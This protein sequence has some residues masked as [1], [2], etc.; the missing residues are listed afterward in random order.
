MK[1]EIPTPDRC[2]QVR[3]D[4]FCEDHLQRTDKKTENRPEENDIAQVCPD[5]NK[6][7]LFHLLD[8]EAVDFFHHQGVHIHAL[9]D[10]RNLCIYQPEDESVKKRIK[11]FFMILFQPDDSGDASLSIIRKGGD[12]PTEKKKG[13]I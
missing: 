3:S 2:I 12:E 5:H 4:K 11:T 6:N 1:K 9:Q 10:I 7:E 8:I 13:R